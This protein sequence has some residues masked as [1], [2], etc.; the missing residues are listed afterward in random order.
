MTFTTAINNFLGF[1]PDFAY[2]YILGKFAKAEI[3]AQKISRK[4]IAHP[5]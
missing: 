5:A 1:K 2:K 4:I 3:F